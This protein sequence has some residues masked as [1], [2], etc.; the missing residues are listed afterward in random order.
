MGGGS[1]GFDYVRW[2]DCSGA[3]PESAHAGREMFPLV[4]DHDPEVVD[5]LIVSA[6]RA[7][8]GPEPSRSTVALAEREASWGLGG[9]LREDSHAAY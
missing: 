8:Y 9:V 3:R 5:G 6:P 2:F 1:T 4:V 7:A